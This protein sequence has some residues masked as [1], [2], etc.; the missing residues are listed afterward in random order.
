MSLRQK[1][2]R[3]RPRGSTSF[4]SEVA[5]AFGSLIREGRLAAGI[6]QESMALMASVE[7]SYYGR[8]ERGESQPTLFVVLKICSALGT[9]SGTIVSLVERASRLGKRIA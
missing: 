2:A 4:D 8:I 3:G 6:S 9:D 5:V 1:P 7:R